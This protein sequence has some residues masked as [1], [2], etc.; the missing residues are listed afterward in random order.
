MENPGGLIFD[1]NGTMVDDM[2][3]HTKAWFHVLNKELGKDISWDEVK[4][5]MYGKNSEVL[6]RIFGPDHFEIE[7]VDRI[8]IDKEKRYQR[9][10]F[11][12][13]AL[14]PGLHDFLKKAKELNIPMAIGSAAIPFNIDFIL[15]NLNLRN[16]FKA[17]VSADDVLFSKPDPETFSKAARLL[18]AEPSSCIVFEDAP[19]GVEAALRADMQCV[20]LT[21]MHEKG[22]FVKYPN[23]IAYIKDFTDPFCK[24]LLGPGLALLN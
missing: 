20:V 12:H 19:K 2:R 13:L 4:S 21:T 6:E 23:V 9:E 11:P 16:F 24:H 3:F 7:E 17:I 18:S 15:D 5:H 10:F 14:I 8:S 1:L 22:E